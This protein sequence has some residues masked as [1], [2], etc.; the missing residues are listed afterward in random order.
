M[1][2][3]TKTFVEGV[4]VPATGHKIHWDDR[5]SGYGLKVTATGVRSF[6]AQGR[7]KGKVVIVTI[8]RFP[9]YTEDQ[10]RKRALAALQR[11][12]DGINPNAEKRAAEAEQVT[13]REV[14]EAYLSRPGKLKPSSSAESRRHVEQV[15]AAW[16][17]KPI[18]SISE[19]MVRKRHREMATMGLRGKGPAPGQANLSMTTLRA[20]IN[21]AS[22]Q[23]RRADGTPL[24]LYNPVDI[25]K[26]HWAKLGTRTQRYIDKATIGAAWNALHEARAN[27]KNVDALAGID[28]ILFLLLTGARRNEGAMLTWDRVHLDDD[29]AKCWWHLPDPKNGREVFLPVS[30]QAIAVLRNR[31]RERVK[32]N[33]HVFPSRSKAGHILDPRAPMQL[34]SELAAKRLSCHDL[35]R[36]FT[37]ISL[38]ECL[39]EKFRTDLLTCH[40]PA[41]ADVTARNYLDLTKLEWLQPEVE[42]IGD[43]IERQGRIAA[44]DNVVALPA[45]A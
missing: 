12:R 42:R 21:F 29:P 9:L 16:I 10:A 23:Y 30:K 18:T 15:F 19:D 37:N 8:G 25:L 22:R 6:I 17:D 35:R 24:F 32:G 3:L 13:L 41:A 27:P 45:R 26:D 4:D 39:I 38:R 2:K 1:P 40:V 31:E 33:P 7:A 20:L 44:G 28:L 34:I 11:M 43:Y 36:T 14:M 5:V